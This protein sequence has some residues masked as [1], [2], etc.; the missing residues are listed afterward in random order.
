MV[1]P[2]VAA[3]ARGVAAGGKTVAKGGAKTTRSN[4]KQT[5]RPVDTNSQ[6][7]PRSTN[8]AEQRK[9]RVAE[10][11]QAEKDYFPQDS[12]TPSLTSRV[13]GRKYR[14]LLEDSNVRQT[15]NLKKTT[16]RIARQ[17]LMRRDIKNAKLKGRKKPGVLA[18]GFAK[19]R[20]YT[21]AVTL[22]AFLFFWWGVQVFFGLLSILAIY[23]LGAQSTGAIGLV[24]ALDWIFR[25]VVGFVGLFSVMISFASLPAWGINILKGRVWLWFGIGICMQ[26]ATMMVPYL[27]LV[28]FI[29]IWLWG[30]AWTYK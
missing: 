22:T 2:L 3:G 21:A 29:I 26:I 14:K 6:L 28:P 10:R 12:P 19:A 24:N 17:R 20:A 4:N 7:T 27:A 5:K 15:T 9:N 25:G 18:K 1:A 11:Q 30:M 16:N 8:I 23:F 13:S